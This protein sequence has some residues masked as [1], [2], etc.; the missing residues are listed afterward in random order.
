MKLIIVLLTFL[1]ASFLVKGQTNFPKGTYKILAYTGQS[2]SENLKSI[3][4]V[5]RDKEY[6]IQKIDSISF[7]IQTT[8][9]QYRSWTYAYT[10]YF[11]IF[12]KKISTYS[13]YST[14]IGYNIG[15]IIVND[16]VN[17]EVISRKNKKS[18]QNKIIQELH[19]VIS[20]LANEKNIQYYDKFGNP[21][22]IK[23]EYKLT[24]IIKNQNN[25]L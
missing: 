25:S 20:N 16:K 13:K 8:P 11:N 2:E 6:T 23:K 10:F 14:N 7:Q 17:R 9:K 15:S 19:D 12:D 5:L 3:I 24:R 18:F 4:K 1:T 22:Q 21:K